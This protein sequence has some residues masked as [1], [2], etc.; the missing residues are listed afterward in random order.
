MRVLV[1][2]ATGF[3]GAPVVR[4]LARRG[5]DVTA[6][7]RDTAPLERIAGAPVRLLKGDLGRPESWRRALAEAP[8]EICLH[9]A[10]YVKAGEYLAS[11]QNLRMF[12]ASVHLAEALAEAGC[13][14]LVAVGTNLEYDASR[15]YLSEDAP[16]RPASLYG[17]CKLALF[18]V[19]DKLAALRAMSFAW[20]RLFYMYGPEEDP[21]RIV[22][23]VIVS[24]L[25]G[26]EARTTPGEQVRDFLHV[27]DAA[28]AL[29]EIALS[30]VDLILAIA[31][32]LDA[33]SRVALG[34]LPYR[35]GDPMFVCADTTK[36]RA[37]TGF[38]PR[39]DL[40]TGLAPTVEWWRER[41]G[42]AGPVARA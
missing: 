40:R 35:A 6:L 12:E 13:R 31:D 39:Y 30:R 21:A 1:T 15:G 34:A 19:L 32:A 38:T 26:Q 20:P 4:E 37:A 29:V 11:P 42:A 9:L 3:V 23:A 5:C 33:R 2:G 10:W 17:A 7:V 25:R 22:P 41:M 24:L 14:R 18:H 8:P 27:D 36:L 28:R 16:T